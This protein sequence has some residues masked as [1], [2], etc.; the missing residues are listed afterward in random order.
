MP[1]SKK[2]ENYYFYN[3]ILFFDRISG[4]FHIYNFSTMDSQNDKKLT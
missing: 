1:Y 3:K 4:T 2:L